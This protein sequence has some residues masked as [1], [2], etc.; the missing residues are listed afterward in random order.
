[1]SEVLGRRFQH[2]EYPDPDL[3]VI[4]GGKGQLASVLRVF[5]QIGRKDLPV[6]GLAKARTESN[7]QA[8]EVKS[9]EERFF[10]PGRANPVT[11]RSNSE[12]LHILTGIRDEAHRFAITYHRKLREG[13][14]LESELDHISGLGEKRKRDLLQKFGSVEVLKGASPEEIAQ[15]KGFHRVLAERILLHL[16]DEEG[17]DSDGDSA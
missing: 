4:D 15:M 11:F 17:D 16:N 2:K 3:I 12:A 10:L 6:V 14:S 7:F 5:E 1:M 8:A 13:T 9:T